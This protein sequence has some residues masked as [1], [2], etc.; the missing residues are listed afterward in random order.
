L[1]L[2]RCARNLALFAGV[3]FAGISYE[4]PCLH[5]EPYH[6]SGCNLAFAKDSVRVYI[7]DLNLGSAAVGQDAD[8]ILIP[9]VIFSFQGAAIAYEFTLPANMPVTLAVLQRLG[10][11]YHLNWTLDDR[12]MELTVDRNVLKYVDRRYLNDHCWE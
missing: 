10:F 4:I 7:G 5:V 8:A 2:F 1:D 9:K 6:R 12:A 11:D 3:S